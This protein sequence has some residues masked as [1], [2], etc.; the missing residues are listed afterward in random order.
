MYV[1]VVQTLMDNIWVR[2][3]VSFARPA[4]MTQNSLARCAICEHNIL[5]LNIHMYY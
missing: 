1:T 4:C 3:M 5:S 2:Y